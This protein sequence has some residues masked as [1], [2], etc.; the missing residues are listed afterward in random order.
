MKVHRTIINPQ[1]PD[2]LVI[3]LPERFLQTAT[4]IIAFAV[5]EGTEANLEAK[6]TYEEA[7]RFWDANAID[8]SNLKKWKREDLYE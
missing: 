2:D 5:E 7:V 1:T 3:H 6:K 4:E 8:F